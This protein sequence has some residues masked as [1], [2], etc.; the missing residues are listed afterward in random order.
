MS[1]RSRLIGTS[2]RSAVVPGRRFCQLGG[3]QGRRPGR[4]VRFPL[5]WKLGAWLARSYVVVVLSSIKLRRLIAAT[6]REV[7]SFAALA[8]HDDTPR[9]F[10]KTMCTSW[11]GSIS[12]MVAV[13]VF[14]SGCLAGT[15]LMPK[16]PESVV[17][18]RE[19]PAAVVDGRTGKSVDPQDFYVALRA[20]RVVYVAERHD[21]SED[22]AAQYEIMRVV[23]K[24][25]PTLHIGFEMFQVPFQEVLDQWVAGQ[26][27]ETVLRRDTEYDERWGF[28][29]GMVRPILEYARAGRVPLVAL[30][31]PREI[32]R[33]VAK[34]GLQS[35]TSEQRAELP[36]MDL[37]DAAHR[38]FVYDALAAHLKT[39]DAEKMTRLYTAQVIWD[40]TMADRVVRS[41]ALNTVPAKLV[42]F[43]GRMHLAKGLGIPKRAAKRGAK[44]YLIVTP[45]DRAELKRE[46]KQKSADYYWVHA[47]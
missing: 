17:R 13:S 15:E 3:G 39:E 47:P 2:S 28:D 21:K 27:D 11:S 34:N 30:N 46:L 4:N 32:T 7:D 41:F 33:A 43:A 40:E 29:F 10:T 1:V 38:A 44:P 25:D 23:H 12:L 6:S 31:A 18:K 35:L 45:V 14:L 8:G 24:A 20:A 16:T 42:I 22:H 26:I 19:A 5:L 37:N 36:A 9:R